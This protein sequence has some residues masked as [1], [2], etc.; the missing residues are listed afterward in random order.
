MEPT[1]PYAKGYQETCFRRVSED[2]PVPSSGSSLRSQT[3]GMRGV[4]APLRPN[5]DD[6]DGLPSSHPKAVTHVKQ[7]CT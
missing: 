1:I 7:A 6:L 3:C 5:A 2:P 4:P